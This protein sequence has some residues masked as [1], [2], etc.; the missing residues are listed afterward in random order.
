MLP[1]CRLDLPYVI[2]FIQTRIPFSP[3]RSISLA[4][5]PFFFSS[6]FFN[7]P[8]IPL[9]VCP[10]ILFAFLSIPNVYSR[11]LAFLFRAG[12]TYP[13][14][15]TFPIRKVIPPPLSLRADRRKKS[16]FFFPYVFL[17]PSSLPRSKFLLSLR[18]DFFLNP[19]D[20]WPTSGL[21]L[22][23]CLKN[24]SRCRA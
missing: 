3:A 12:N 17:P 4:L 7:S 21:H 1:V 10:L 9:F 5:R 19:P 18:S 20:L 6:L 15:S 8:K 2:I 23:P 14:S 22:P 16:F 24:P 11:Q 13:H